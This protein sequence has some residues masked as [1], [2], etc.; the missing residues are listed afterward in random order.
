MLTLNWIRKEKLVNYLLDVPFYTL[1]RNYGFRANNK[2][3]KY[4]THNGDMIIHGD[5][6]VALKVLRLNT[7]IDLLTNN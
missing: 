2:T 1:E 6:L 4:E 7:S 5:N 3:D